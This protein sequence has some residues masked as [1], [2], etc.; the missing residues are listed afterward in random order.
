MNTTPPDSKV[1]L[2]D[3][4]VNNLTKILFLFV[5]VLASVMVAMK[6]VDSNWYR[7]LMRFVLLFSY[8]IPISL[9][10]NLD[11]AKLFYAWQ[12]G[13]DRHIP[14]TVVRSSTIPEEL[15]RISFLLSDKTGTL[16][17]NEMRFKKIHLG[18]VSFSSDAFEDVSRHVISAY[19]G[20]LGRHSF[21]SKVQTAVEAIALCHNVT[22]IEENGK[23]SYQAASPDEVALVQWTESVGVR[24]AQRDLQ[25]IQLQLSNGETRCFQI[26]HLFPFT[27]ET[28]RMGIIVKDETT[29]EISLLMKGADTVMSSMVQYND[30]LEEE[31]S[32]MAR[33][34]SSVQ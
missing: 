3:L 1:G 25:S 14:E 9:R 15:G 7:Y 2:L 4:E 17:M 31:C 34:G 11:M 8:I 21:S 22:P 13:R 12:I 26:L 32:N 33:E 10:V 5:V 19:S 29:D 24:L 28:K 18:T 23:V 27:S 30:W 6:G 16:T 20:K